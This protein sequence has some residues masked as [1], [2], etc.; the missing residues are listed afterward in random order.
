MPKPIMTV[1]FARDDDPTWT[2]LDLNSRD[3]VMV[4]RRFPGL[5]AAQLF[6][7]TAFDNLYKA[8]WTIARHRGLIALDLSLTQFMNNHLISASEAQIE[9]SIRAAGEDGDV[10]Q[11]DTDPDGD[12]GGQ[13]VDPDADPELGNPTDQGR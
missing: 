8:V 4:E 11:A 2:R 12:A 9:A 3:V 6:N 5:T 7:D 1:G 13:D 10:D